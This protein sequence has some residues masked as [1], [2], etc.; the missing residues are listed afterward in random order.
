MKI[1]GKVWNNRKI[2]LLIQKMRE[3]TQEKEYVLFL[4]LCQFASYLSIA[5]AEVGY[6]FTSFEAQSV[7]QARDDTALASLES[8]MPFARPRLEQDEYALPW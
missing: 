4:T 6:G 8:W 2:N 3:N 5:R 1:N 7:L